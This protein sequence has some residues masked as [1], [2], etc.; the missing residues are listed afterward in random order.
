MMLAGFSAGAAL[1]VLGVSARWN[2]WRP[3]S[4]GVPILMYHKIGDPPPGSRLKSLWVSAREFRDQMTYLKVHGFTPVTF[5]DIAAHV[6]EGVPVPEKPVLITFDDGYRNNYENAF[7]VLREFGFKAVVFL[8]VNTV[9]AENAWH[10]P[11]TEARIS[12]LT[13]AQIEDMRAAGIEFGSHTLNHPRLSRLD[14]A[15]A[16][17][18]IE[19]SRRLLG[20]RFGRPPMSFAYPYGDGQDLSA[21][22]ELVRKAGYRWAVSVHQGKADFKSAPFCLRRLFIRGDDVRWDFHLQ[23]TRGKSRF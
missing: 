19:E 18:E 8:V 13:W 9:E 15:K 10:D 17:H 21:L 12:M 5:L 3:R 23:M 4:T 7:P 6:D 2:W 1:V 16:A 22:Q 11:A 20:K 14:A